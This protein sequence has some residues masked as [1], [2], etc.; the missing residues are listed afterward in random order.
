MKDIQRV[1]VSHTLN[2]VALSV[3]GVYVPAYL[4]TLHYTLP[5]VIIYF[6]ISHLVGLLIGLFIYVPLMQKWGLINIFKLNYP[7]QII[8]LLLL[9]LLQ[10]HSFPIAVIAIVNG[11]AIFA[12]WIPLNLLFIKHSKHKDMGSNLAKFYALPQLFGIIGPLIG[13][14]LIPFVGFWPVFLLT[15]CG[16]ILSYIPLAKVKDTG[17]TISLNFSKAWQRIKRNKSLFLF[18]GFDNVLEESNW[19]WGIYVF[20]IIGSLA[21]PGIVG[22]LSAIGGAVFTLLV[23]KFANRHDKKLIPIAAILMLGVEILRMTVTIPLHAYL[24]TIAGSFVFTLF[25]VSYFSTIYRTVKGEGEEEFIILREIPTV[26]GRMIVF[27]A[28]FLTLSDLKY[29][30][31]TP[32]I[33]IILL[34]ML[35][36]WKK[37]I[38]RVQES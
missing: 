30:F 24:L 36:V 37:K 32:I 14:L 15:A 17:F 6:A 22:S 5:Q 13:A 12:Y 7:L 20:I 3:I 21:T 4:L 16:L 29:F 26:L 31:L 2:S 11:A 10:Y 9:T 27:G 18:E 8:Y 34:L 25:V 35:Y 19:F 38:L 23:G 28:I 33:F 1:Y